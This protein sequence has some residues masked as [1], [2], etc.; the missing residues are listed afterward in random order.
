MSSPCRRASSTF[1]ARRRR[2]TSPPTRPCS[3]WRAWCTS[4]CSA[5]RGSA[6]RGRP[7]WPLPQYAKERLEA[8][9]ARAAVS[10]EGNIQGVCRSRRT[11]CGRGD[12]RRARAT[13]STPAIRS[14]ATTRAR[15]RAAR[16]RDR[17]A[18]GRGDRPPRGGARGG[19]RHVVK[20][21]YEK[22]RPGRRGLAVPKPD[23][24]V[25]EVPASLARKS[26]PRLPELAEPEVLRHFTELSTRNFG[27]D[28]RLLSA[29]LVHDEV[30]P[31]RQRAARRP[32]RIPGSPSARRGRD[33]R[34]A[35]S[36]SSG[37]SRRSCAR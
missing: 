27:I 28:T 30:Q 37:S 12:Q 2:R 14:G 16:R 24:P 20:L 19:R 9:R 17:E 23:L 36:S 26:P 13:A 34:R 4:R 18:H 21:I 29:R 33:D 1:G 25:P 11:D 10:R 22:S 32:A 6:R 5:R 15:R 35:R 31:A 7:A 3:P 8:T